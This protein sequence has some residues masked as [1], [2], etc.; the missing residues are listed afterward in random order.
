MP[1]RFITLP[2]QSSFVNTNTHKNYRLIIFLDPG[3]AMAAGRGRGPRGGSNLPQVIFSKTI[4]PDRAAAH[5][6]KLSSKQTGQAS[7][8]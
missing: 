8:L 6:L 4:P 3:H 1:F 7:K 2:L 5:S